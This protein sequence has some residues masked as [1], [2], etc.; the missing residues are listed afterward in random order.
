M[1]DFA[2]DSSKLKK[3]GKLDA[4]VTGQHVP[5]W[6]ILENKIVLKETPKFEI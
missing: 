6:E 2:Q 1:N 4:T 3:Y 5:I